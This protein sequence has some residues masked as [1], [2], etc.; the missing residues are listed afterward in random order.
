MSKFMKNSVN[1]KGGARGLFPFQI[2][3]PI[4]ISFYF[5]DL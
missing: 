4:F 1:L 2:L 3:G 5:M